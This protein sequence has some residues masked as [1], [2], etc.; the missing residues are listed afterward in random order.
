MRILAR[1]SCSAALLAALTF[2]TPSVAGA[3]QDGAQDGNLVD[4]D[5]H[6]HQET[7]GVVNWWSW[8]YGASATNPE[9]RGWPPPFGWALVNFVV[10]LGILSRILWRPLKE[11]WI[12]R[13]DRIKAELGEAKRLHAEAEAQLAEYTRKVSNVDREVDALLA[14]L[15]RDAEADRVR[16]VAA[17]EAEAARLKAEAT[18]QIAAEIERARAE[19]R[20]Q[21]VTAALAAAEE[22]L[23][24]NVHAEDQKRL[25]ERYVADLDRIDEHGKPGGIA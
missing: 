23:K 2:A 21:A 11:G 25:A 6:E 17:A 18:R 13:H 12:G 9:H 15:R 22:I 8:D 20:A 24:K 3:D 4:A 19:L 16:L 14:E 10:F 1:L 5:E 7:E